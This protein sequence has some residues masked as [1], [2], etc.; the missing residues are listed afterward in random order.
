[1]QNWEYVGLEGY[2]QDLVPKLYGVQIT[3]GV[4]CLKYPTVRK[5]IAPPPDTG[6]KEPTIKD[7]EV[8]HYDRLREEVKS[9]PFDPKFPIDAIIER[10]K[11][12]DK[13]EGYRKWHQDWLDVERKGFLRWRDYWASVHSD[14]APKTLLRNI[15][16]I[17]KVD[18]KRMGLIEGNLKFDYS[19]FT[20]QFLE[21]DL[22]SDF[23]STVVSSLLWQFVSVNCYLK[24]NSILLKSLSPKGIKKVTRMRF[25]KSERIPKKRIES[26]I[27]RY[28]K[29]TDEIEN[30]AQSAGSGA[31]MLYMYVDM[32]NS[33]S[34]NKL[35]ELKDIRYDK[36]DANVYKK[37]VGLLKER[38]NKLEDY[39]F[40]HYYDIYE[41]V[42]FLSD[43]GRKL[44]SDLI[45]VEI[46]ETVKA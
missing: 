10:F 32:M 46:L 2:P 5:Q 36:L 38:V 6:V 7:I 40:K 14:C 41:N 45:S 16:D 3:A 29:A 17:L 22:P 43:R 35:Y 24:E 18:E 9:Y 15:W 8:K 4:P 27:K 30:L 12:I 21:S 44:A 34:V 42:D 1:M 37:F 26:E 20:H 33:E 39:I 23:L 25:I 31:E 13:M 11:A 19:F 28:I